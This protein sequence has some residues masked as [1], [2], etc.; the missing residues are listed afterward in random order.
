MPWVEPSIYDYVHPKT[1]LLVAQTR[2]IGFL[3]PPSS[4]FMRSS[5]ALLPTENPTPPMLLLLGRAPARGTGAKASAPV[6]SSSSRS[7]KSR[8]RSSRTGARRLRW[9]S[10]AGGRRR[11]NFLPVAT[12][13]ASAAAGLGLGHRM[14]ET[15]GLWFGRSGRSRIRRA[16]HMPS[17]SCSTGLDNACRDVRSRS[18][19]AGAIHRRPAG[20]RSIDPSDRDRVPAQALRGAALR[21]CVHWVRSPSVD[22]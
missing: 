16:Y 8:G 21:A 13:A 1:H 17:M 5:P 12:A 19:A 7:S 2:L 9:S 3:T 11:S 15:E 18:R 10:S 14:V 4:F 20:P 6:N 22:D